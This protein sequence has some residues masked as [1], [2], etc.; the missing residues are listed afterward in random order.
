MIKPFLLDPDDTV[1]LSA[2]VV[3]VVKCGV[4]QVTFL[5]ESVV[6]PAKQFT[7]F[8]VVFKKAHLIP[9]PPSIGKVIVKFV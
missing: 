6:L 1:T 4:E 7:V 5:V 2:T 9:E 3:N 8:V